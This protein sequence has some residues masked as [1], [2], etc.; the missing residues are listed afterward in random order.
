[1]HDVPMP[2]VFK[3]EK[4]SYEKNDAA[5]PE[6]S[7]DSRDGRHDADDQHARSREKRKI[8]I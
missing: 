6:L 4:R 3:K 7:A 8:G 1:M 5:I 2:T